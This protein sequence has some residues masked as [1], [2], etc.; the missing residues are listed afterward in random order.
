MAGKTQTEQPAVSQAALDEADQIFGQTTDGGAIGE[1]EFA[2]ADDLLNTVEEDDSEGWNPSEKNEGVSGVIVKIGETRSDFAKPGEDPMVPTITIDGY[3]TAADGETRT[4]GK[5]RVIG[6]GAVLHRELQDQIDAG[7]CVVGNL[8]A[9][10]YFGEKPIK[11]GPFAG[12]NY[13]HYTVVCVPRK[14]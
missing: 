11:R 13:R 9:A 14:S 6:Y 12:K 4:R 5:F 7:R 10:K 3:H 1:D 2:E 8:M